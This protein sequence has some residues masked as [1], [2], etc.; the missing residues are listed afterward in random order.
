MTSLSSGASLRIV[1]DENIPYVHQFFEGFGSVKT[2]PGREMRAGDL[3]EADVLL[4]RSVTPVNADLLDGSKVKFVG[5]CTIGVDHLDQRY[6]NEKHIAY[7][8]APGCNAG[9]VLQYVI[10]SVNKLC[11][12]W[13]QRS[14]GVIGHGNV[15]RRLC[16]A[17]LGLNIKCVAY[18]PFQSSE[19]LA[20]L[21]ELDEVLGQDIICLH[22]P[23]TKDGPFPSHHLLNAEQLNKLRPDAL[24]LNAGRGGVI[25]NAALL[26]HMQSHPRLKVVLDVW[27]DEPTVLM[28]LLEQVHIAT[29]HIAGYSFEGRV[30]GTAMI[31]SALAAAL[32]ES[33]VLADQRR[34]QYLANIFGEPTDLGGVVLGDAIESTYDIMADHHRMLSALQSVATDKRGAQFDLLRKTYPERHE[35]NQHCIEASHPQAEALRALEFGIRDS[36]D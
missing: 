19:E 13:Q 31:Y 17:L 5:T 16:R 21:R 6:L 11:P 14:F 28:A 7:A 30:M 8:S 24:L 23:Y 20:Y 18:D 4:V 27:E 36:A 32:G 3:T 12:D 25:H 26:A 15:G 2:L 35:F 29:P 33:Q 9:G 34:T 1:A 22:A 10:S